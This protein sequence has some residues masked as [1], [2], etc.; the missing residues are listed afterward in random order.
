M[1]G[2]QREQFRRERFWASCVRARTAVP[3]P[4]PFHI[5]PDETLFGWPY[6][7]TPWMPGTP[8][9]DPI[10]AVAVGRAAADLRHVT[11]DSFGP[12]SPATDAVEPF[13]GSASEWLSLRTRRS[14]DLC[15]RQARA[16]T[17]PDLEYV[18]CLLPTDLDDVVPTYVHHDLKPANCVVV[19]GEVSGLFDL[20]E[21][22][23]GDPIED[24]A[25]STWSLARRDPELVVDFLRA[26]E[27]VACTAVSLERLWAYVVL[28]LLV[29][30]EYGTRPAQRWFPD[31]TFRGWVEAFAAPVAHAFDLLVKPE[32]APRGR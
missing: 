5:E 17:D 9:E 22:T 27:D 2:P 31:P 21:G 29:I 16:L 19:D 15:A 14:I 10:G 24:L 1:A 4:W 30:W 8:R 6:Q 28:D 12:W 7:L 23:V 25:R 3:V 20:G 11:F 32:R 18:R 13:D 26:Y